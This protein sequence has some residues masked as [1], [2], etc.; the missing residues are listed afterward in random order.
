MDTI[1]YIIL[2]VLAFIIAKM[3]GNTPASSNF[4]GGGIDPA[5]GA[6]V[7]DSAQFVGPVQ[8]VPATKLASGQYYCPV[9][10]K[11]YK[12]GRTGNYLCMVPS[13]VPA[14]MS[15]G[16]AAATAAA[17]AQLVSA[18]ASTA[19][20][21]AKEISSLFQPTGSGA[22]APQPTLAQLGVTNPNAVATL[23]P[24]TLGQGAPV[25]D[26]SSLPSN[27]PT[28]LSALLGTQPTA[29]VTLDYMAN[30]PLPVPAPVAGV[31]PILGAGSTIDPTTVD[32]SL[33]LPNGFSPVGMV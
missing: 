1:G 9:P 19:S 22:V 13:A 10:T 14:A 33:T 4:V 11:L 17:T 29:T 32:P 5:T 3:F 6:P 26:T 24:S 15:V 30:A 18:G 25:I 23:T 8:S 27:V 2:G 7:I 31:D 28:D 12:D 20:T 16:S 21:I